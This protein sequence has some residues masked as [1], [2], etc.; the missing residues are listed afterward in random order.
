MEVPKYVSGHL[1]EL[2]NQVKSMMENSQ[3][4]LTE[5]KQ[6]RRAKLCKV[7]GKEGSASAIRDHIEAHHHLVGVSLLCDAY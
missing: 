4:V 5:S 1:Q 2:H 6:Q 7:C 3:N